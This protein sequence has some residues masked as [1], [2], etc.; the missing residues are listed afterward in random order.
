MAGGEEVPVGG[1]EVPEVGVIG[2][3]VIVGTRVGVG[4]GEAQDASRTDKTTRNIIFIGTCFS[5][6]KVIKN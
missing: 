3:G 5:T 4:V 6:Y 2:T 1:D